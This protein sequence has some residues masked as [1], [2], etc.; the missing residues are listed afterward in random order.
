MT[1]RRWVL[2]SRPDGK[3]SGKRDARLEDQLVAL[4]DREDGT[5]IVQVFAL[6]TRLP[7]PPRPLCRAQTAPFRRL[8]APCLGCAQFLTTLHAPFSRRRHPRN[9]PNFFSLSSPFVV[10][11]NTRAIPA[12]PIHPLRRLSSRTR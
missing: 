2:A 12:A 8:S 1:N 9:R 5:T 4:D 3:F 7:L 10:P 6:A 11:R